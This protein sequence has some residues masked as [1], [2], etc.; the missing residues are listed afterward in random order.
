MLS[1]VSF[2]VAILFSIIAIAIW[3]IWKN[4]INK[5]KIA[6]KKLDLIILGVGMLLAIILIAIFYN[7]AP[8]QSLENRAG[9][10]YLMNYTY[11]VM[12][13]FNK[14]IK[15]ENS[16]CLA[17][18]ISVFPIVLIISIVYIFKYEDKHTEF[19][20]PTLLISLI[21]LVLLVMG[22]ISWLV[23]NYI[24]SISV[25]LIQI[26]MMIY[27][28]A[29]AQERIASLTRA[30]YVSLAGIIFILLLP[31]PETISSIKGREL[32][33]LIFVLESYIVLNY[34][35]KR[36]WRVASWI[37]PFITLFE[38]IGYLIVNFM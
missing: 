29:N 32:P 33:Y 8:M 24:M 12:T 3:I 6:I 23:P 34:T 25:A 20:M 1:N 2:Q 4:S 7:Y 28:F 5:E 11:S 35:D 27:I 37:F 36:F 22:K 14:D 17:T 19:F 10:S 18:M 26:Y 15:F 9:T 21:L 30:A 13:P 31:F 16:S 38:T